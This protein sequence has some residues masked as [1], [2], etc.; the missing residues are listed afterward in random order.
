MTAGDHR[1]PDN[2]KTIYVA[3]NHLPTG[4]WVVQVVEVTLWKLHAIKQT[5]GDKTMKIEH[6]ID[7]IK[8]EARK[9]HLKIGIYA[10][11]QG[12]PHLNFSINP[13]EIFPIASM[14]KLNILLEAAIRITGGEISLE[15]KI[16]IQFHNKLPGSFL[17]KLDPGTEITF[18]NLLQLMIEISDNTA[19]DMLGDYFGWENIL[20]KMPTWGISETKWIAPSRFMMLTGC[21]L[22]PEFQGK[23]INEKQL[24]WDSKTSQEKMESILNNYEETKDI[25]IEAINNAWDGYF[26]KLNWINQKELTRI[27][28]WQGTPFE[29]GN[30]MK[31]ISMGELVSPEVSEAMRKYL[32][33][34]RRNMA[35]KCV[36]PDC[37][38]GRKGGSDEGVRC[39]GVF[40]ETPEEEKI[41]MAIMLQEYTYLPDLSDSMEDFIAH[42]GR[43][44]YTYYKSLTQ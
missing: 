39:E 31:K 22:L 30:M 16:P 40:I 12:N 3:E 10:I 26:N 11:S 29:Y 32:I 5:Q 23:T 38:M 20:N 19:T 33:T 43:A 2:H 18:N 24:I 7:Y 37:K 25:G 35:G 17:G 6:I 4:M 42:I 21:D 8:E 28:G 41:A 14:F 9:R 44:I 1:L 15:D 34:D 27:F 13:D 36:P